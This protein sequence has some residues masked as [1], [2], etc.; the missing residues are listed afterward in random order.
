[1]QAL[2]EAT[3]QD[4]LSMICL[5]SSVAARGGN[6]GQCDY[7]MANEV[8]NKVGAWERARRGGK[9]LV[10]SLNWGPWEGGMVTPALEAHF[11]A[12]GVPLIPLATGAQMLVDELLGSSAERVEIVMGGDPREVGLSGVQ[13]G[14]YARFE[15]SVSQGSHPYLKDHSIRTFRFFRW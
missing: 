3:E 2:L 10:K 12:M 4:P 9:C 11:K 1:M 15:I 7:A 8:L 6:T 13:A 14:P 5:F